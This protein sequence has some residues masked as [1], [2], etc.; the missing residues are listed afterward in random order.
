MNVFIRF[1]QNI[2]SDEDGIVL[3]HS[4][5]VID[6][7][8]LGKIGFYLYYFEDGLRVPHSPFLEALL[9][10]TIFILFI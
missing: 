1:P 5:I 9:R 4:T 10:S 6:R 7:P 8:S 2:I 3:P